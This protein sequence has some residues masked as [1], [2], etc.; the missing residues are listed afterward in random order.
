MPANR[1]PANQLKSLGKPLPVAGQSTAVKVEPVHQCEPAKADGASI[2]IQCLGPG[3]GG[4]AAS[5]PKH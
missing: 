2:Y 4:R 1:F 5:D 3:A